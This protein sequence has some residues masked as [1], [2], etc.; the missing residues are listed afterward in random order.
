[1]KFFF[2]AFGLHNPFVSIALP[3]HGPIPIA[4]DAPGG[5][6]L[7]YSSLLI[8][9]QY[10]IDSTALDFVEDRK[11]RFLGPMWQSLSVLKDEGLLTIADYSKPCAT[12][13]NQ[14]EVK[15]IQLLESVDQWVPVARAQWRQ[16][17][18]E[19]EEFAKLYSLPETA[20]CDA[21]HCGVVCYLT[22]R[23]GKVDPREYKRLHGLLQSRRA[24]LTVAEES[25][26]REIL[27]PLIAQVLIND[28][29]REQFDAPFIDWDDAKGYYGR[30]EAGRW[31]HLEQTVK[32][33]SAMAQQ[34]RVLFQTVVPELRPARIQ[35]VVRFIRNRKAVASL[36][37]E[38]WN[39][40]SEGR[41]VSDKWMLALQNEATKAHLRAGKRSRKIRWYGRILNPATWFMPHAV[42]IASEVLLDAAGESIDHFVTGSSERRFE[43]Y[44]ALQDLNVGSDG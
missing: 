28:L 17:R 2:T 39:M 25:E 9:E 30:L 15:T 18:E 23:D 29:L 34:S 4:I 13:R 26:F 43:W 10:I 35:D 20:E 12:Y 37:E 5:L 36:R 38:L 27:K 44:Y 33:T 14:I 31:S 21:A 19:F 32:P 16:V 42:G 41:T 1:M 40:M 3:E 11:H 6:D 22:Q 8:A 7:D 24:R